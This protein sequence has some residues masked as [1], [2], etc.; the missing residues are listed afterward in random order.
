MSVPSSHPQLLRRVLALLTA[1]VLLLWGAAAMSPADAVDQGK[2]QRP[3]KSRSADKTERA[4]EPHGNAKANGAGKENS[5]DHAHGG[6][7]HQSDSA[8][9]D[10]QSTGGAEPSA[11]AP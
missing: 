11:A 3:T 8:T 7:A 4:S 2:E 1:V 5:S 10:G 6:T 9:T